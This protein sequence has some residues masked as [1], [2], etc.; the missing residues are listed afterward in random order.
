MYEVKGVKRYKEEWG[1]E[2]GVNG[3]R[4]RKRQVTMVISSSPSWPVYMQS[5]IFRYYQFDK[6]RSLMFT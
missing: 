4:Q 1:G 3:Q 2:R 5:S 6:G